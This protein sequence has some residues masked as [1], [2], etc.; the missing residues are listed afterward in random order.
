MD[1]MERWFQVSPDGGNGTLEWLIVALGAV[2][3]SAL[4]IAWRRHV[5]GAFWCYVEE[6]G[7]RWAH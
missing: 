3:A 5:A 6:L 7:K 2:V 4:V 1:F